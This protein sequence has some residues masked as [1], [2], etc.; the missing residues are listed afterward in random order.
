MPIKESMIPYF[1]KIA[2]ETSPTIKANLDFL[3]KKMTSKTRED[4]VYKGPFTQSDFNFVH[5][6]L[7]H[8]SIGDSGAKVISDTLACGLLPSL[9]SMDVSD[10]GITSTGYTSLAGAIQSLKTQAVVFTL[11]AH[12]GKDAVVGFL[13]KGAS[14]YVS[15]LTKHFKSTLP[16]EYN[17]T[18]EDSAFMFCKKAIPEA[19]V[20]ITLGICKCVNPYAKIINSLP[21]KGDKISFTTKLTSKL[22]IFACVLQEEGDNIITYETLGC[23]AEIN[24]ELDACEIC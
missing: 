1:E 19:V 16:T 6:N 13:K 7:S 24:E 14:Y 4:M 3:T 20:G 5:L 12:R 8:C 21:Q 17:K 2:A 15:E 22:G 10:N 18:S 11:Q 9:R 23:A